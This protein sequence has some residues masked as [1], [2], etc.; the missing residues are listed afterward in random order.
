MKPILFV[1]FS[2]I[3][4][5]TAPNLPAQIGS[6]DGPTVS[7]T[8]SGFT[9]PYRAVEVSAPEMGSIAQIMVKEGDSVTS[10]TVLAV[11][12]DD[13][14]QASL[15]VVQESS[16]VTGRLDSA[17]AELAMYRQRF[18]KLKGLHARHHASQQELDRAQSQLEIAQAKLAAVEDELRIK[19]LEVKRIEAQL[20]QRKVR[21]PIDGL[22]SRIV[23]E[24]GEYVS[25]ADPVVLR[26]VQIDP[27]KPR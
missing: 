20:E 19:G 16:Q 17:R 10:G 9:E 21:A 8:I 3:I 27:L 26:L 6:E 15:R 5:L 1:L 11:L 4:F 25:A 23:K 14:L 22:V 24:P 7:T 12:N 18:E 13:V 2:G